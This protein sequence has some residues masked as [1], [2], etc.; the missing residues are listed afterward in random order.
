MKK[1][2]PLLFMI[3]VVSQIKAQ[4]LTIKPSDSLLFKAPKNMGLQQ[5][6]LNDS[7]LFKGFPNLTKAQQ[8][9]VLPNS[10]NS[11]T[12]LFYSNMPVVKVSGNIDN[13]PVAKVGGNIDRMP[14]K[15][16]K[17]IPLKNAQ[18]LVTP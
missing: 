16:I 7:S 15:S 18:P 6:K 13:M 4:Q 3:A 14:I 17:V 9:A 2:L 11:N 1:I 10:D 8:L 5:F 12:E